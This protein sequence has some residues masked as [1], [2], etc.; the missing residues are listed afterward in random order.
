MGD[1]RL[2]A[3]AAMAGIKTDVSSKV[4]VATRAAGR[5]AG[6]PRTERKL[7]DEL[8]LVINIQLK[9]M[10]NIQPLKSVVRQNRDIWFKCVTDKLLARLERNRWI[11]DRAPGREFPEN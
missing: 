9:V 3:K 8:L 1:R 6:T 4:K 5:V 11:F 7:R 10:G 2:T